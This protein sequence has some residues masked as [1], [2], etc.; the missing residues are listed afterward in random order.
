[1]SPAQNHR[2]IW[3][4]VTAAVRRV[5]PE[6]GTFFCA[7]LCCF[8][9]C[10]RP[11]RHQ[12]AGTPPVR[13][14]PRRRQQPTSVIQWNRLKL[15]RFRDSKRRTRTSAAHGDCFFAAP[16]PVPRRK[17]SDFLSVLTARPRRSFLAHRLLGSGQSLF[18]SIGTECTCTRCYRRWGPARRRASDW[19]WSR[20]PASSSLS[21]PSVARAASRF[22]A[23]DNSS[24]TSGPNW[25]SEGG[26][27]RSKTIRHSGTL[28][29]CLTT[30][31][32]TSSTISHTNTVPDW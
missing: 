28:S 17:I 25:P 9:R 27:R 32:R 22:P 21:R 13:H 5:R 18:A 20:P 10:R 23:G 26:S 2:L 11:R 4:A 29:V 16:A 15:I 14:F 8:F 1:M 12:H 3:L 30:F 31:A 7:G 24:T 19:R 6:L